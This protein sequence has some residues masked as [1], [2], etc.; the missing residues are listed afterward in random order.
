[1]SP[2]SWRS[3]TNR[4]SVSG[5]ALRKLLEAPID[6]G[7]SRQF[8]Y[9]PYRLWH[10]LTVLVA[11]II[12]GA[13]AIWSVRVLT[14]QNPANDAARAT[15]EARIRSNIAR[16]DT[17]VEHNSNLRA[18]IEN[19]SN[20]ADPA[21][22]GTTDDALTLGAA[23]AQYRVVGPGLT[24]TLDDRQ[25]TSPDGQ[26]RDYDFHV[27]INSLWD[28][29]AEAI[30]IN[31]ERIGPTT[32]IRTAGQAVQVNLKPLVPPYSIEV[33]GDATAIQTAFANLR[34]SAHIAGLRDMYQVA[35]NFDNVSEM[36][37]PPAQQPVLR[38]VT[39]EGEDRQQPLR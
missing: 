4:Q 32:A 14:A 15:L 28:A 1:M 3:N 25:V 9:R 5:H 27:V 12:F 39:V 7:Y 38:Y 24:I 23:S 10:K 35:V 30:A 16:L 19:Y 29:G 13:A 8:L 18:E 31:G 37:L 33:I 22:V 17:A 21:H 34:G 20:Q 11:C 26:L 2:S 36:T 6:V